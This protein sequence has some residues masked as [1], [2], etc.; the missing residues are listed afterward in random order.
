MKLIFKTL[1]VQGFK[2]FVGRHTLN[3][4]GWGCGL[5]FLQGRN[6]L[7]PR[8]GSN[9]AGKSSLFDALCWCLFGKTSNGLK[10]PDIK[11]WRGKARTAVTLVIEADNDHEITRTANP[12]SLKIDGRDVG[13]DQVDRLLGLGFEIFNQ[14]ILLPQGRE[15]FFDVPPAAKMQLFSDVLDLDR[16]DVRSKRAAN[17]ADVLLDEVQTLERER[18]A[19]T[20][21][22]ETTEASVQRTKNASDDWEMGRLTRLEALRSELEGLEAQQSAVEKQYSE[23]ELIYDEAVAFAKLLQKDLDAAEADYSRARDVHA[24]AQLEIDGWLSEAKRKRKL[25]PRLS[26]DDDCPTCGQPLKGSALTKHKKELEREVADLEKRAAVGPSKAAVA[27]LAEANR[28]LTTIKEQVRGLREK[29]DDAG[30]G[31]SRLLPRLGESKARVASARQRIE[32]NEGQAN[33]HSDELRRLRKKKQGLAV[34]LREINEDANKVARSIERAQFW[35]KGF[36]D[37]RLYIVEEV[38]QEL[39]L[40]TNAVLE[41]VGLVGWQVLYAVEKETKSGTVSRAINVTILSPT[42]S[43]PVRW[44]SWSGGEGQRL[45]MVGALALSEVLLNYAGV[46]TNLEVLDEPTRHLSPEG[47][48]DMCEFLASRAQRA[49]RT[50]F[51]VDHQSVES[52]RFASV[53]TV[54]KDKDGS[55]LEL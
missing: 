2:S 47:I 21:V 54:V 46:Q 33:P 18:A 50:T 39:E 45:R 25:I 9:G 44:E 14:T 29:A 38:L 17:R 52:S 20:A 6:E 4:D 8:L 24:R 32:E 42:N 34:Q 51:Y 41:D 31:R 13:Q 27:D 5:L 53:L 10:N 12:N 37:I 7:E 49:E 36:R 43:G 55:Y 23:F 35:V 28:K 15:L 3:L 30:E 48:R 19:V 11:P 1:E 40:T 22:I 26:E 16:W